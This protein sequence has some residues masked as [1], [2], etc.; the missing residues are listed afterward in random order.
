MEAFTRHAGAAR[1][2]FNHALGMKVAAHQQWRREVQAL[3]DQGAPEAEAR[4][5]VRVPVLSKPHVQKAC[6]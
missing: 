6:G 2:A 3:V 1:W 5:K 4:K